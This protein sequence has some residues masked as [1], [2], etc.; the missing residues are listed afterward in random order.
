MK[1]RNGSRPI[2]TA[3]P[4]N[5]PMR[6]GP[7]TLRGETSPVNNRPRNSTVNATMSHV[8]RAP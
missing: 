6:I 4:L 1:R 2:R 3:W 8:S 5:W 7:P